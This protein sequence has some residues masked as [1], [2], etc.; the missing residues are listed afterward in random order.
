MASPEKQT[1]IYYKQWILEFHLLANISK[2]KPTCCFL[3]F[4]PSIYYK[5]W[6]LEF[7]LLSNIRKQKPTCGFLSFNPS[8]LSLQKQPD[9]FGAILKVKTR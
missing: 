6:I 3:S 5:Q 8:M 9:S 2:Q 4:N 1:D 7:H